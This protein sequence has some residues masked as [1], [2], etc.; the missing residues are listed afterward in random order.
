MNGAKAIPLYQQ[1]YDELKESIESGRYAPKMRIPSEPELAEEFGVSRI[2]V[3]RAVEELAARGYLIKQQGRGTFVS[4]PHFSRR[5]MQKS[6][7]C[8]FSKLC[9]ENGMKP[10]ARLV[11]RQIVP[12]RTD[13]LEFFRLSEKSLLIY[14]QRIR[15]ADGQPIFEE[16]IFV[17]YEGFDELFN[18]S[19]D[20]V[21]MF[22]TLYQISG[23]YVADQAR[24]TIE[25]VRATAEQASRLSVS[26]SDPLLYLNVQFLDERNLPLYIGKQYYVGS[27]YRFEL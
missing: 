6:G 18:I 8:S 10:G 7:T 20:D 26:A 23:H 13:E 3:R 19:L 25:A 21:S 16:N 9:E 17:P 1:I 5:L 12:A 24:R 15:T 22:E 2:T 4:V 14:V 11:S 27:R